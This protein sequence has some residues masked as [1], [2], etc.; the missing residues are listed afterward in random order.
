MFDMGLL[1]NIRDGDIIDSLRL[2][3]ITFEFRLDDIL[4][5][6]WVELHKKIK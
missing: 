6:D 4:D 3:A 5:E 2:L 1:K